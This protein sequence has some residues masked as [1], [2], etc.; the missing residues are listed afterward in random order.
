MKCI[1]IDP[2]YNTGNEGWAYNDNVNSPVIRQWIGETVGKEGETLDRHDRWLCMMY[3]RLALLKELLREDGVIFVSIDG[4]EVT[5]LRFILDQIFGRENFVGSIV[6]KNVT[7]NNPTRISEEHEYLLCYARENRKLE[8]VW[9]SAK[10]PIKERLEKVSRDFKKRFPDLEK[11]QA[12]YTRWF[13]E[14]KAFMW[15]FDRYKYIDDGGIFT[16][17]QSVHNPGKEGYR[18]D[19]I[20]PVTEMPCQQPLMGYRFPEETMERLLSERRILFGEDHNKIIEIKLYAHEYKAKLPSLIEMDTRLGANE[21]RAIFPE[22]KRVFGFSKPSELIVELISFATGKDDLILDSFAGSGTTGHA[23]LKL[24]QMD[25]GRRRFI[26]VEMDSQIASEITSERVSRVAT[27]YANRKGEEVSGYGGSF[28]YCQ[29]GEPLFD[30]TGEIRKSVTFGELARHVWFTE[31]GEPLP[32]QRVE[33]TPFLG[34]YR[35]TGIFLLY[36]GI[37]EDK[38]PGGGN[39]LTRAIL[40]ELPPFNGSRVIYCAGCRIGPERLRKEG[41]IVRQ[42]PYEIKVS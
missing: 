27:G 6:W 32:K 40:A 42:T 39:I 21:L 16:G 30:E 4:R 23:V 8:R 2:P 7:D 35:G 36:N 26:L 15:P 11:R 37:L 1:Y 12:A 18:Y 10:L 20:H 19:V 38:S 24:N 14:N 9:K 5:S 29:L 33:R 3:P 17:S 22:A 28:R 13:R 31:T 25:E 34:N 41:I